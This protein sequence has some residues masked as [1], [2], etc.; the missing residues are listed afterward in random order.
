VKLRHWGFLAAIVAAFAA[1]AKTG[2]DYAKNHYVA[3]DRKFIK[4]KTVDGKR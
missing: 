2:V 3:R 4:G 1:G